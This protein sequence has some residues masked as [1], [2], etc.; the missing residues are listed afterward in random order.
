M[1]RLAPSASRTCP[2]CT[3]KLGAAP[4][5]NISACPLNRSTLKR[6]SAV[7]DS[8][9]LFRLS[10]TFTSLA[11]E[12][13]PNPARSSCPVRRA[14]MAPSTAA[15]R[16][17]PMPSHRI[18]RALPKASQNCSATSPL[19]SPAACPARPK[20]G[21]NTAFSENESSVPARL[22]STRGSSMGRRHR[23]LTSSVKSCSSSGPG[24]M[25]LTSALACIQPFSFS[26][27]RHSSGASPRPCISF[28]SRLPRAASSAPAVRSCSAIAPSAPA[29]ALYCSVSALRRAAQRMRSSRRVQRSACPR[30]SVAQSSA[31][32][33]QAQNRSGSCSTSSRAVL[34]S[35]SRSCSIPSM[36]SP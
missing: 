12:P 8:S 19:T 11:A 21:V 27:T 28:S 10:A 20:H 35:V 36:V 6:S 23:R 15:A 9:W 33:R 18:M 24:L 32:C 17:V 30:V 7:Q 26:T 13:L 4:A 25:R 14:A 34:S 2:P 31:G 29:M 5:L 22:F 3:K 1:G 16:P